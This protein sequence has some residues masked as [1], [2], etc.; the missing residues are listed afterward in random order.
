MR[1]CK[2]TNMPLFDGV[3]LVRVRALLVGDRIDVRALEQT[4]R[5]AVAPLVIQAGAHGAA[6]VFRWGAV[7][8]FHMAPLEEAG[9]LE[10]LKRFVGDPLP[11]PEQEDAEVRLVPDKPE[12]IEGGSIQLTSFTVERMQVIAEILGRSVALARY[13]AQVRENVAAIESWAKD[14]EQTGTGGRLERQLRKHLGATLL[15]Q[16]AMAAR[17]E[18]GDKPELLWERS[19]LERLYARLE[20]E[21]ELKERDKILDR[22]LALI[23]ATAETLLNIVANK[24]SNR[25]EWYIIILILF[26]IVL[27]LFTM[28]TGIGR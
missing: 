11:K 23:S 15:I 28:T 9:L 13:E 1:A 18:I 27:S 5:L 21:Y 20:D 19:D 24:H 4:Q 17:V 6:V 16:H 2:H 3:D 7:V 8:L 14:L 22:K 26:E 25:L 12:G 10:Q